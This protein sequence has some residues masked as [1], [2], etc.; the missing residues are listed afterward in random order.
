MFFD[1]SDTYSKE[2]YEGTEHENKIANIGA[3]NS[4][5]EILYYRKI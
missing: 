4:A 5:E 3:T 2:G 1:H